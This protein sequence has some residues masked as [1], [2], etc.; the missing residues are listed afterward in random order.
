MNI[1]EEM[2]I[3]ELWI[4]NNDPFEHQDCLIGTYTS[5]ERAEEVAISIENEQLLG[6][7]Y[8]ILELALLSE[9]DFEPVKG[10]ERGIGEKG[11]QVEEFDETERG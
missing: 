4:D 8:G 2:K 7:S 10:Y 11:W 1:S 5:F 3:Y 6:A 9:T